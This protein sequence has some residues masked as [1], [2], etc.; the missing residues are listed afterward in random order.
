MS[1]AAFLFTQHFESCLEMEDFYSGIFHGE[2][3][4]G[5]WDGAPAAKNFSGTLHTQFHAF[6]RV[7]V[8]SGS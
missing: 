6:L 1:L 7:L 5:V 2:R 4:K 8:H 3:R